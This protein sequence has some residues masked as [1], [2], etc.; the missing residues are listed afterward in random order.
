MNINTKFFSAIIIPCLLAWFSQSAI[1]QGT[2]TTKTPVPTARNAPAAA[3]INGIVY[4]VGGGADLSCTPSSIV[5][6][7]DPATNTWTTKAPMPTPRYS[8]AVVAVNQTLYAIGGGGYC[9]DGGNRATVEA[10]NPA[11]DIWTTK[12]SF[13]MSRAGASR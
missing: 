2:W 9:S 4:V 5:E 11:T 3:S 1:A 12:A 10:Y 8:L 6:A 13:A 7:Y